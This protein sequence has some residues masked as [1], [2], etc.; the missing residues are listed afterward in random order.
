VSADGDTRAPDRPR[1]SS[2]TAT[3]RELRDLW[4][5]GRGLLLCLVFTILVGLVAYVVAT[6]QAL[7]YLEQRE[8]VNLTLQVGIAVGSLA[9][10]LVAADSVSGER[11]RS[12]LE[13]LLL[14]P[15]PRSAIAGGKL[16]GALSMWLGA[17]VL[18]V[19]YLWIHGRGVGITAE[20]VAAGLTI[21]SLIAVF[22]VSVGFLAS[23]ASRSN[24]V[25]L[26]VA[27]LLLIALFAPTQF[28]LSA[29]RGGVAEALLR[30]NPVT[31]GLHVIGRILVDGESLSESA[32]WLISPVVG[33]AAFG[34]LA[35]LAGS[36]LRLAPGLRR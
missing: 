2:G 34:A 29:Q 9:A 25:S 26:A 3:A 15:A 16:A 11:E 28:P 22:L 32:S 33:A 30:V 4:L 21:G 1:P 19:P 14:T 8:A 36:R 23:I 17:F 20:A 6:N 10:L 35:L 7:N 18:T 12:T 31:A 5:G 13:C 24:R 27:L